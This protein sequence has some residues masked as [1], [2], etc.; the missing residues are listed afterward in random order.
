MPVYGSSMAQAFHACVLLGLLGQQ[1]YCRESIIA[2]CEEI[3]GDL[4]LIESVSFGFYLCPFSII[5]TMLKC[6]VARRI[7]KQPGIVRLFTAFL[8]GGPDISSL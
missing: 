8:Q 4:D 5:L 1:I 7:L 2:A 3:S 6:F